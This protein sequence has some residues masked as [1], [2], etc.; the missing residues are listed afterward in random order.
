M[1]FIF[2]Y[3][4]LE[5]KLDKVVIPQKILLNGDESLKTTFLKT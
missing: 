5:R 3:L 2:S 4:I 1:Y